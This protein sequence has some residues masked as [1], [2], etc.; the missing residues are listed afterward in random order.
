MFREAEFYTQEPGGTVSCQL[1]PHF[2][3]LKPGQS[4]LCHSRSNQEGILVA[5]NYGK[6]IGGHIDVIEKKP[7]YHFRPGSSIYSLGPNSCNLTCD[8]CQNYE[9]SQMESP[10]TLLSP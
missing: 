1:C 10:Y 5:T 2:C 3:I 9:I 8:F 7:L 6:S 4:G